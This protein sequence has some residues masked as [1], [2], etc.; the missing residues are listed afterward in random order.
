MAAMTAVAPQ[1]QRPILCMSSSVTG[2]AGP[3]TEPKKNQA[4]AGLFL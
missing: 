2:A 3:E 1:R 4:G